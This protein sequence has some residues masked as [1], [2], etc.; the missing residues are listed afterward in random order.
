[1]S[2]DRYITP[3]YIAQLRYDG[4]LAL[5]MALLGLATLLYMGSV[6][7]DARRIADRIALALREREEDAYEVEVV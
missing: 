4:T 3:I 1:M 5:S 6:I 7:P 2:V